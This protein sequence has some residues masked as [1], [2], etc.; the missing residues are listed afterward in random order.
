MLSSLDVTHQPWLHI[1]NETLSFH[2]HVAPDPVGVIPAGGWGSSKT[3][4]RR[5]GQQRWL[6][7]HGH[8][9]TQHGARGVRQMDRRTQRF[10]WK[11]FLTKS[12]VCTQAYA[13]VRY[14]VLTRMQLELLPTRLQAVMLPG[15][16]FSA[17]RQ[18]HPTEETT[19]HRREQSITL[20]CLGEHPY[21]AQGLRERGQDPCYQRV[22]SVTSQ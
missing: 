3:A 17:P 13:S 15:S 14:A 5:Q 12:G 4:G 8:S 16:F 22:Q 21:A 11:L 6:E 1:Y 7:R 18:S 10:Q 20:T 19:W 2:R 9:V